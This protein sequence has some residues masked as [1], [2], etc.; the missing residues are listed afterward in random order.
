MTKVKLTKKLALV[1]GGGGAKGLAHIGVLR[2]LCDSG[3]PISS[4]SGCSMG[5]LIAALFASGLSID[6][7]EEVARRFQSKREMLKLVD[8]TPSRKGLVVG[9]K[10]R[11]Y[12][13]KIIDP[14][15]QT[16]ETPIPLVMNAIDLVTAEEITLEKGNILD[17]IMATIAV[18]G[19]F[20]PVEIGE[21][22]LVDGGILNNVPVKL[23]KRYPVDFVLAVDVHSPFFGSESDG[24]HS[25]LG[26]LPFVI[27]EFVQDFYRAE[28]IMSFGLTQFNL[29]DN[30]PDL[31]LRPRIP[32]DVSL[33]LGF[34]K[35]DDIINS[36]RE[37]MT[38]KL[39]YLLECLG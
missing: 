26:K 21:H 11:G 1:L 13:S 39:P 12:L 33:F 30:P 15:M 17:N 27:P 24:V 7:I 29:K 36:G 16:E 5:G 34:Q 8:R 20:A 18:P 28:M 37:A 14:N 10:V 9:N 2:V 31:L 25:P 6:M 19:F 35:V 32:K 23:A 22:R 3:I 4:I 38:E